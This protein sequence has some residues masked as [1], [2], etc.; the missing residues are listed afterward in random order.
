MNLY[1][2]LRIPNSNAD[3][4]QAGLHPNPDLD[5]LRIRIRIQPERVYPKYFELFKL[6]KSNRTVYS[7]TFYHAPKIAMGVRRY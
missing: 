2:V 3:P 6:K 7:F 5:Q 1:E 4:V